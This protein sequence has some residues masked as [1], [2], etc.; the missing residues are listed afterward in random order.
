MSKSKSKSQYP[1]KI[2]PY[3][4][5]IER[6]ISFGITEGQICTYYGVGRTQ[7]AQY[8]K[9]NAELVEALCRGRE[10]HKTELINKAHEIAMGYEYT[11]K[12]MVELHDKEGN[13]TG[14][15]TTTK[16]LQQKPDSGMI[17]FLLI[18]RYHEEFARDPQVLAMRRELLELKKNIIASNNSDNTEGI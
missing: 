7:W 5:D 10:R 3:I 15:K 6:Y 2:Q 13:I 9:N 18:N 1:I 4:T 8:K 17:Q 11:E 12:I 16:K 14:T